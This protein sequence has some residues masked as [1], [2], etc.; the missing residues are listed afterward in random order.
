MTKQFNVNVEAYA[1]RKH[2]ICMKKAKEL[3]ANYITHKSS[4]VNGKFDKRISFDIPAESQDDA[5][6][7]AILCG[8]NLFTS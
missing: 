3:W 6:C 7:K 5:D 1:T 4:L 2:N 8:F